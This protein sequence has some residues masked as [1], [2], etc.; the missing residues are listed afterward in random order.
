MPVTRTL[1]SDPTR[2]RSVLLDLVIAASV[3]GSQTTNDDQM[4]AYGW[5]MMTVFATLFAALLVTAIW[6]LYSYTTRTRPG[7]GRASPEELLAERYARGDITT[8]EYQE[9]LDTLRE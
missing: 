4:S 7:G 9:R 3:L 5:V 2:R 8:E 6:A 1:V